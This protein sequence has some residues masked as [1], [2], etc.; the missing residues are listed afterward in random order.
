MVQ[1][2]KLKMQK[3]VLDAIHKYNCNTVQDLVTKIQ[4]IDHSL[5]L[6]DICDAVKLLA[7]EKKIVLA[8]PQIQY[9]FLG[10]LTK[11]YASLPFWVS[12]LI[13]AMTLVIAYLPLHIIEEQWTA[14]R[15][16]VG[17]ASML[18]IPGYAL[19]KLIFPRRQ[20]KRTE[21]IALTIGL[22]LAFS[23]LV[24]LILN[25]IFSKLSSDLIVM[26]L[27]LLT[28]LLLVLSEYRKFIF[29]PGEFY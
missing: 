19:T 21:L 14:F 6:E 26:T 3:L 8:H 25:H 7:K 4:I 24:G 15:G 18:L 22:S 17:G 9:S 20:L 13:V 27:S 23:S 28:F 1:N 12:V 10:Y 2:R 5:T 16:F 29:R 11:S